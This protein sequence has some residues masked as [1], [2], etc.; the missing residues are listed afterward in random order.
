MKEFYVGQTVVGNEDFPYPFKGGKFRVSR[1]IKPYKD[2]PAIHLIELSIIDYKIKS[3]V[4]K[5]FK[6][7]PCFLEDYRTSL[8]TVKD[9]VKDVVKGKG[10]K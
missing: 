9:V 1:L 4:G 8:E 7:K 6:A 2:A 10:K 3:T 5:M